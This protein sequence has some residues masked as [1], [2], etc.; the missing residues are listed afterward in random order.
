MELEL[1][2]GPHPRGKGGGRKIGTTNR[3][4][5]IGPM[6]MR[7]GGKDGIRGGGRDPSG[8]RP[9]HYWR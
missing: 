1:P 8:Q 6:V 3:Q 2:C 5:A 4:F 9:E 7:G